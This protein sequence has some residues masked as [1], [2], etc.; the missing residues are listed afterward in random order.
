VSHL[1]QK[2]GLSFLGDLL[3]KLSVSCDEI[4]R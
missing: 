1:V 2:V 3:V 4:G